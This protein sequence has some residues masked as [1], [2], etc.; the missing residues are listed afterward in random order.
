MLEVCKEL[1]KIEEMVVS[2]PFSFFLF[3]S[4]FFHSFI[5]SFC[6]LSFFLLCLSA[7]LFLF[8][9]GFRVRKM[10]CKNCIQIEKSILLLAATSRARLFYNFRTVCYKLTV[11]YFNQGLGAVPPNA[12]RNGHFQHFVHFQQKNGFLS[13]QPNAGRVFYFP[14]NRQRA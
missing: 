10:N 3:H 7:F 9:C 4:F 8:C 12:G 11:V 1:K 13:Q 6:F 14:K 2:Q 5:H